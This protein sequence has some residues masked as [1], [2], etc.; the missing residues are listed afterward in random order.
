MQKKFL[1]VIIGLLG[2]LYA[3]FGAIQM[4]RT[5]MASNPGTAYGGANIAASLVPVC[6]GLAICVACLQK[7]IAK[8]QGI[9]STSSD[10]ATIVPS[11]FERLEAWLNSRR[12]P[13]SVSRHEP[14]YTSEEAARVRG[15]ALSSGAK[16]LIVKAGDRFCMLVLPADRRLDSKKLRAALGVKGS[17]FATKEEVAELTGL[18][19]GSIPPF[20]SF[21]GMETHCDQALAQNDSI[22]FNAA[23]H[24]ISIQMKYADYVA[25]EKPGLAVLTDG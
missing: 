13:F 4:I 5:M 8:A 22:N 6:L 16:A 24:G 10:G 15:T 18:E 2:G 9:R 21:F 11:L 14:V 25:V 19:P 7:S 3:I 20:G 1:L 23:D 17:R 12:V